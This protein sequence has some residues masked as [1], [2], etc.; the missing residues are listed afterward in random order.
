MQ[1]SQV[2]DLL[3]FLHRAGGLKASPRFRASL[4]AEG[5]TVAEHSWRLTLM[6]F[7]IGHEC[8]VDI[9]IEKALGIALLHDLAE[10]KTGDFDAYEF[11]VG[12]RAVFE[13]QEKEKEAIAELTAG[14][15]FGDWV[16][17][18][19]ETFEF[20]TSKEAK[21]VKALDRMEGFL[22]I[23]EHGVEAYIPKEFHGDYADHAVKAFD[24]ASNH[25]PE[26]EDLLAA[27]KADLRR[28]FDAAGV[29]WVEDQA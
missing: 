9:D 23:A 14:V 13:K 22:H 25:F 21:F 19:W 6:V 24:E 1:V 5:D 3:T 10:A 28:Q 18:I 7:L 29:A 16:R 17:N 27:I 12:K 15:A 2:K 20:Q 26:L 11:M 8:K 4:K